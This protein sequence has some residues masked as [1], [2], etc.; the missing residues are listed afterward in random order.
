MLKT[1]NTYTNDIIINRFFSYSV[2]GMEIFKLGFKKN[3]EKKAIEIKK[4]NYQIA[5]ELFISKFLDAC[6]YAIQGMLNIL[7]WTNIY[8]NGIEVRNNP[9]T[10]SYINKFW[11]KSKYD[12]PI[13]TQL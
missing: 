10:I 1:Y 11:F 8:V 12:C 2:D 7:H 3:E 5:E 4:F 9:N 13:A 6:L